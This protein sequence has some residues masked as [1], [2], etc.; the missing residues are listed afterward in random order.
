MQ[1]E[2]VSFSKLDKET[3][4][5]K[6]VDEILPSSAFTCGIRLKAEELLLQ[7]NPYPPLET[8]KGDKLTWSVFLVIKKSRD[9]SSIGHAMVML[10]QKEEI[11]QIFL[12]HGQLEEAELT[13]DGEIPFGKKFTKIECDEINYKKV[14]RGEI[15]CMRYHICLNKDEK[16]YE[17]ALDTMDNYDV[18]KKYK[19]HDKKEKNEKKTNQD[20]LYFMSNSKLNLNGLDIL[21][22][23]VLESFQLYYVITKQDCLEYAKKFC[24]WVAERENKIKR[25]DVNRVLNP[26]TV[27]REP[28]KAKS[29]WSSR[30]TPAGDAAGI[31]YRFSLKSQ[32]F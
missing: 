1:R 24:R 31:S 16:G 30:T 2:S 15:V 6:Y 25:M 21:A 8:Y 3:Y 26:L 18:L 4:R 11:K 20:E 12:D 13:S 29:E 10:F 7:Q 14:E 9:S 28:I 32:N 5:R 19:K 27:A 23:L 17:L 22:L